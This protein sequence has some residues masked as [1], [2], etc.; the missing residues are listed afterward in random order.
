MQRLTM[1]LSVALVLVLGAAAWAADA[2]AEKAAAT[3]A[4]PVTPAANPVETPA[5]TVAPAA[6]VETPAEAVTPAAPVAPAA[7]ETE[8]AGWVAVPG[9][10][11]PTP[12]Y[13]TVKEQTVPRAERWGATEASYLLANT[14]HPALYY[15]SVQEKV[16][17]DD[18]KMRGLVG[19]AVSAFYELVQFPVQLG[20]TPVLMAVKPPWTMERGEP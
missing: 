3:P 5:A 13:A 4:V 6:P 9:S 12:S 14:R 17:H 19:T 10:D 15:D 18:A 1:V 7:P 2:A 20:L 11:Q 16:K 8:K